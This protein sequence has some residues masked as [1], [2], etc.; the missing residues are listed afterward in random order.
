MKTRKALKAPAPIVPIRPTSDVFEGRV[1]SVGPVVQA[2]IAPDQVTEARCPAHIDR[3][4]LAA[5][6]AVG[7]V[8]AAF[9]VPRNGS[10]PILI[11]LF[12]GPEHAKVRADLKLVARRVRIEAD[13]VRLQGN[14]AHVALDRKGTV[15][16][17]GRDVTTRATRINRLQGGAVRIN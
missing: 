12:P 5:A 6:V 3:A 17:R 1:T 2:I 11:G 16:V 14:H 8:E 10:R 15:E 9:V 4:W 7:P 13:E